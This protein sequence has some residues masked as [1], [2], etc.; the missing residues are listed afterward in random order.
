MSLDHRSASPTYT[1]ERG[2][3]GDVGQQQICRVAQQK[4]G[5]RKQEHEAE[6]HPEVGVKVICE[7]DQVGEDVRRI[8]KE[9]QP[10]GGQTEE[11][12]IAR[13]SIL[14]FLRGEQ[15]ENEGQPGEKQIPNE[16]RVT[17]LC[18]SQRKTIRATLPFQV[19]FDVSGSCL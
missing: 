19:P 10:G 16:E 6:V 14:I 7:V 8:G 17:D 12:P 3:R 15:R 9:Q 11:P 4:S 18:N 1:G 2:L 5:E 13:R